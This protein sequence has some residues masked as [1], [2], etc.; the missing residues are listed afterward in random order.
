MVPNTLA[1]YLPV[2]LSYN[3]VGEYSHL[4]TEHG[5]GKIWLVSF[6]NYAIWLDCL[7]SDENRKKIMNKVTE[8]RRAR[9]VPPGT[10]L[11][12]QKFRY[13]NNLRY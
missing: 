2:Y 10:K 4:N 11:L 3:W 7:V 13:I 1:C 5:T 9:E 8:R 6:S 12:Y